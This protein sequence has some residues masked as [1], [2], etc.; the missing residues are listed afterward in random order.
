VA[1]IFDPKFLETALFLK[2]PQH[3]HFHTKDS[4]DFSLELKSHPDPRED[5]NL[6]L[7][8]S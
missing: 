3:S 6:E 7:E 4:L 5:Q 2:T 1:I 8:L